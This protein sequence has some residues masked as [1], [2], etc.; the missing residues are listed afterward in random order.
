MEKLIL[1]LAKSLVDDPD[2]VSVKM[3]ETS[4]SV[5]VQLS[6]AP[7]DMGKIIGKHGR[8]ANAIRVVMKA[9]GSVQ[10]K[11]VYVEIVE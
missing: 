10:H 9:A 4:D 7:D 2:A 5:S 3:N 6:V 11:K 1:H 8:I